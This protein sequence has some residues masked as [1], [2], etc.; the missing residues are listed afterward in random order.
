MVKQ[1]GKIENHTFINNPPGDSKPHAEFPSNLDKG[2]EIH[3]YQKKAK[4]HVCFWLLQI[5]C[6]VVI[7]GH[8]LI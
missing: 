4:N 3:F 1:A 2:P 6:E 7:A 8:M 5:F